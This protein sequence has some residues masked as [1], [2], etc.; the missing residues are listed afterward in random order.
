MAGRHD[1]R[2]TQPRYAINT[3]RVGADPAAA[4]CGGGIATVQYQ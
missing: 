2:P 1:Q 3:N 4:E